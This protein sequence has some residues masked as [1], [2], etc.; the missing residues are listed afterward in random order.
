MRNGFPA[1]RVPSG[2][3]AFEIEGIACR[4]GQ[5]GS[6]PWEIVDVSIAVPEEKGLAEKTLGCNGTSLQEKEQDNGHETN[7]NC[8]QLAVPPRR[9]LRD[10]PIGSWQYFPE[11]HI[12]YF[13]I[14]LPRRETP[15]NKNTSLPPYFPTLKYPLQH[16]N[17]PFHLLQCVVVHK[18][19]TN[20][21]IFFL[22]AKILNDLFRIEIAV[23]DA[24]TVGVYLGDNLGT[25]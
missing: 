11:F 20:Y 15:R 14:P 10:A 22:K 21:A 3:I 9:D 23:P 24:N 12:L 1:Q 18:T 6:K 13:V 5:C 16:F 17:Q 4:V 25:F 7:G 8:L 2:S 19:H